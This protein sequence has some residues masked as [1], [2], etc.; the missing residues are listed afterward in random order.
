MEGVEGGGW[1]YL[2]P[3][4]DVTDEERDDVRNMEADVQL[5]SSAPLPPSSGLRDADEGIGMK[6]PIAIAILH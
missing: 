6:L 1:T 4:D 2:P 3:V 5:A